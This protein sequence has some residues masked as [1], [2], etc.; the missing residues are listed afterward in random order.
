MTIWKARGHGECLKDRQLE[1]DLKLARPVK[2]E[3]NKT[4]VELL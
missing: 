1:R 4:K 3:M 2:T